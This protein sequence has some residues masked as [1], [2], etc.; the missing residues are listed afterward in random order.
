MKTPKTVIVAWAVLDTLFKVS[1]G[2][3]VGSNLDYEVLHSLGGAGFNVARAFN[4]LA[5]GPKRLLAVMARDSFAGVITNMIGKEFGDWRMIH[6]ASENRI[7]AIVPR[8]D[9]PGEQQIFTTRPEIKDADA[10]VDAVEEELTG[11]EQVFFGSF[12]GKDQKTVE[13]LIDAAHNSGVMI[14]FMPTAN[15]LSDPDQFVSLAAGLS[16]ND[17]VHLNGPELKMLTGCDGVMAGVNW[18]RTRRVAASCIVTD[19]PR[20]LYCFYAPMQDWYFQK[21]FYVHMIGDRAAGDFV[22]GTALGFLESQRIEN[23]DDGNGGKFNSAAL[24]VKSMLRYCAAAAA[25]HVSG[26]SATR[27]GGFAELDRFARTTPLLPVQRR[28]RKEK[29][30]LPHV[31]AEKLR[32]FGQFAAGGLAGSLAF[33]LANLLS[34]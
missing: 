23:L 3:C 6:A 8:P 10:L 27:R 28:P 34:S 21:A 31:P 11:A 13:R 7:S 14:Y 22:A 25:I 24:D 20:G 4:L 15:Q 29:V 9:Q 19:G 30:K 16:E 17:W 33:F 26:N 2:R 12:T 32:R 18:L 1:G 5:K